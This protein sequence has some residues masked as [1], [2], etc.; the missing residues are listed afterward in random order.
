[1]KLSFP[2]RL[3]AKRDFC[4][5]VLCFPRTHFRIG[6]EIELH[7]VHPLFSSG[8]SLASFSPKCFSSVYDPDRSLTIECESLVLSGALLSEDGTP[9]GVEYRIEIESTG[10][11]YIGRAVLWGRQ[12][13]DQRPVI[14]KFV[15]VDPSDAILEYN[16]DPTC[17]KAP[18]KETPLVLRRSGNGGIMSA[19]GD[20]NIEAFSFEK[21]IH[22]GKYCQDEI[23]F[24]LAEYSFEY[25]LPPV[26]YNTL[27][28]QTGGMLSADETELVLPDDPE[29]KCGLMVSMGVQYLVF[30]DGW[31][32]LHG[33]WIPKEPEKYQAW[34]RCAKD[35]G[36]KVLAYW[37]PNAFETPHNFD[38]DLLFTWPGLGPDW[39]PNLR[40]TN[41]TKPGGE[42]LMFQSLQN[43]IEFNHSL[44]GIYIDLFWSFGDRSDGIIQHGFPQVER[45]CR[46]TISKLRNWKQNCEILFNA[47]YY[48][49][50][51]MFFDGVPLLGEWTKVSDEKINSGRLFGGANMWPI[52]GLGDENVGLENVPITQKNLWKYRNDLI[53]Q[54]AVPYIQDRLIANKEYY[55][56]LKHLAPM[57]GQTGRF[58]RN[59]PT[60]SSPGLENAVYEFKNSTVVFIVNGSD[61]AVTSS[62]TLDTEEFALSNGHKAE[63]TWIDRPESSGED[64]MKM[65]KRVELVF[66]PFEAAVVVLS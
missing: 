64:F 41:M 39:G 3:T 29:K 32:E 21:G 49:P 20:G 27:T 61:E 59:C 33:K 56:Y 16:N 58:R 45:L 55:S 7:E 19:M 11:S 54:G 1:M 10:P 43:W 65:N 63:F 31:Q 26:V 35:A 13:Y 42:K 12:K 57:A 24:L 18:Y 22:A 51:S 6:I 52:L 28:Q 25:R 50:P 34:I 15:E 23:E 5:D 47:R 48:G 60:V 37:T 62:L 66:Q 8:I 38:D 14:L 9:S 4:Y 17:Y 36:M 40:I 30:H 53:L 46:K 2:E 44:D